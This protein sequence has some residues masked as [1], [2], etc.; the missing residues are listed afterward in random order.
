MRVSDGRGWSR[1][2]ILPTDNDFLPDTDTQILLEMITACPSGKARDI[3][4]ACYA[5]KMNSSIRRIRDL[6][7]RPYSTVREWLL[8]VHECGLDN[9]SDRKPP[10]ARCILEAIEI[11]RKTLR[12][13]PI[14][15]GFEQGAWLMRMIA[16]VI[17]KKLKKTLQATHPA[18]APAQD[19]ILVRKAQNR[20][21]QVRLQNGAGGVHETVQTAGQ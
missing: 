4:M 12:Q 19:G 1:P 3:L 17:T 6:M 2:G 16:E 7:M 9:I 21:A 15:Y 8:R 20:S 13:P 14:K 11:V 10:G 18:E 5:R